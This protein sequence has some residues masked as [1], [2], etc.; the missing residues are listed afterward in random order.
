MPQPLFYNTR[1]A[2]TM[3]S[4]ASDTAPAHIYRAVFTAIF[5]VCH[6]HGDDPAS[7]HNWLI[8]A[9]ISLSLCVFVAAGVVYAVFWWDKHLMM[10]SAGAVG[11]I[12]FSLLIKEMVKVPRSTVGCG[13]GYS[14]P[15]TYVQGATFL[16]LYFVYLFWQ[17]LSIPDLPKMAIG[18]VWTRIAVSLVYVVLVACSRLWLGTN[19]L[20][21]VMGGAFL[22]GLY[23]AAFVYVTQRIAAVALVG[24]GTER[25]TYVGWII[26]KD[27]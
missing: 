13:S 26:A 2:C 5:L 12:M 22:G 25:E 27:D 16:S 4:V 19:I 18:M 8:P 7:T 21:D 24:G 6:A 10:V 1:R 15:S 20:Q 3:S 9:L 11:N 17:A 23:T 14:F